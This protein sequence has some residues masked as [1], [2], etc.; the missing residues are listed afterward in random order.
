MANTIVK[1]MVFAFFLY[2]FYNKITFLIILFSYIEFHRP[3]LINFIC[4]KREFVGS[5]III[6]YLRNLC[7]KILAAH[8]IIPVTFA[9]L[10]VYHLD[11]IQCNN[12][13]FVY[14]KRN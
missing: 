9:Q 3:L 13:V 7:S 8:N 10:L 4:L 14:T 11:K 5:W 2:F 12:T 6:K 1:G